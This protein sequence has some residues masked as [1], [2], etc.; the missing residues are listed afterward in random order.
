[1]T[2]DQTTPARERFLRLRDAVGLPD[3]GEVVHRH[4]V[5]QIADHFGIDYE[6]Y[7][8]PR[9]VF[10]VLRHV[11]QHYY[12]YAQ[13]SWDEVKGSCRDYTYIQSSEADI[14]AEVAEEVNEFEWNNE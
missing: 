12:G 14:I 10:E 11:K 4:E 8:K 7:T 1:M 6:G 5:E 9:L 13:R 3:G 2:T